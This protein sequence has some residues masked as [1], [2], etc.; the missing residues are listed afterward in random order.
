MFLKESYESST[1][2]NSD[3]DNSACRLVWSRAAPTPTIWMINCTFCQNILRKYLFLLFFTTTTTTITILLLLL[4]LL[5]LLLF[6]LAATSCY[7]MVYT[8]LPDSLF[9]EDVGISCGS[10][11]PAW[12]LVLYVISV[13]SREPTI[14]AQIY[15]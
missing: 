1:K 12:A 11:R 13:E 7:K 9:V 3:L 2:T 8:S 4:L 14:Q 6:I 5:S 10:G 15:Q